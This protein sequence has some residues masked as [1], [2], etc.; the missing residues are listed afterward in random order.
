M[1]EKYAYMSHF[2]ANPLSETLVRKD[3]SDRFEEDY[4]EAVRHL[5]TFKS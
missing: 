1:R 2:F 3:I 5:P 4:A